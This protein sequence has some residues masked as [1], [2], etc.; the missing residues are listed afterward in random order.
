MSTALVVETAPGDPTVV[1]L[2]EAKLFSRITGSDDDTLITSMVK[3]ATG[4]AQDKL[5]GT[6]LLSTA[7]V[8][9]L[10][11]WPETE[12]GKAPFL[13]LPV[14]PVT[15]IASVKYYD[16]AGVLQT[17]SASDYFTDLVGLRAR[18]VLKEGI[19][20]PFLQTARPSPIEVRFTAGYA[21]AAA[22]PEDIKHWIKLSVQTYNENREAFISGTVIA[23][24]PRPY[25]DGLLDKYAVTEFY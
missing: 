2:A 21:N 18:I 19:T 15:A 4:K 13:R 6:I 3:T 12:P 9:Y 8:W 23:V 7:F 24:S 16:P 25:V 14:G 22:V 11:E 5:G 20:W 1:T 10:D 17:M